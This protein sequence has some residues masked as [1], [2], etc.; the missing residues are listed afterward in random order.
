M[1]TE[2]ENK[3]PLSL[4]AN[5]YEPSDAEIERQLSK[6]QAQ[7]AKPPP[8]AANSVAKGLVL[9][10]SCASLVFLGATYLTHARTAGDSMKAV[11]VAREAPSALAPAVVEPDHEKT[12]APEA[13]SEV[14]SAAVEA[15]PSVASAPTKRSAP[16]PS[17]PPSGDNDALEREARLLADAVRANERGDGELA[18]VILDRHARM[19]PNGWLVNERAAER[20]MVLCS[21]G[22]L[23]QARREA[24]VFLDGRPKGPLAHRVETSCAS[25]E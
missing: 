1:S 11:D 8:A 24:R 22:K 14:P 25:Q 6:I 10:I 2:P 20:I 18:L 23:E 16:A 19:F 7:L 3:T 21:L 4:L 17:T 9:G 5:S 15:L 12:N 13:S